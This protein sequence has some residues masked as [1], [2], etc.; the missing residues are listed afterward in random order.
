MAMVVNFM[1]YVSLLQL[2]CVLLSILLLLLL[3][4]PGSAI[5]IVSVSHCE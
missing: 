5:S 3:M 1:Q 2:Y 4:R